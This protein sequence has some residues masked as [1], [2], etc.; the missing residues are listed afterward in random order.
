MTV[1]GKPRE[2][3]YPGRN[4]APPI[5]VIGCNFFDPDGILVEMNQLQK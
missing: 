1:T 3:I 5:R 4:G 2:Q